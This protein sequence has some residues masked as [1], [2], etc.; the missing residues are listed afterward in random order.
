MAIRSFQYNLALSWM[1]IK[2]QIM[3]S[4]NQQQQQQQQQQ[5]RGNIRFHGV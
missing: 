3:A 5:Q 4:T 2:L 1:Q